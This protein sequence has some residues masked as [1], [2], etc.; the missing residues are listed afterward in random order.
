MEA[1]ADTAIMEAQADVFARFYGETVAVDD[2]VRLR[3]MQAPHMY[4]S[5]PRQ[6][7]Y[8]AG[9]CGACGVTEAIRAEGQPAVDRWLDTL[10]AG[11][12][13]SPLDLCGEPASI[14]PRRRAYG[15]R[16]TCSRAWSTT[17]NVT[18]R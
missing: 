9:L 13:L 16:S 1:Q 12:S 8:A 2:G 10:R 11:I 5:D 3:W 14:S 17:W 6:S 18:S 15:K 4:W 7:T